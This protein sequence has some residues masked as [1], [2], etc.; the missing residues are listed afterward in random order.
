MNPKAVLPYHEWFIEF[1]E[2]PNNE[3][4]FAEKLDEAMQKQNG[5]YKDLIDGIVLKPL[6]ITK[7]QESGFHLYMKS[8]GKLGGQNKP[9][10]LSNNRK[11]ANSLTPF[12][13][14]RQ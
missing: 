1:K 10:R 3:V 14:D 5:Y 8:E 6:T 13:D 4:V 9:P 11:L 2:P 7:V 12:L